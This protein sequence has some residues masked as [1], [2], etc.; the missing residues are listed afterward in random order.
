MKT[1]CVFGDSVALGRNDEHGAGWPA[2]LAAL[3]I[4]GGRDLTLYNL[5]V[6][7]DTSIDVAD[8]WQGDCRV[9]LR[10]APESAGLVFCFG[11]Y[12]MAD[13]SALDGGAP[14]VPLM[15]SMAQA[16]ALIGAAAQVWPVLWIGPAPIH[17]N[18]GPMVEDGTRMTVSRARLE[19]LNAAYA[20]IARRL[21]VP[22][23][24]LCGVLEPS[25]TWQA[26]LQHGNG[27]HPVAAGHAAI[28]AAVQKWTA[29][30]AWMDSGAAA[31]AYSAYS[32]AG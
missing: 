17:R 16:E 2:R 23:L 19:A 22:F 1:I 28:A 3:E 6:A 30:R 7:Q 13:E 18:A 8:R 29:W 20:D 11:L 4:S 24:N 21:G 14:R 27:I 5:S 10:R 32:L 25:G 26:A 9:R 31:A 15:D 12:D